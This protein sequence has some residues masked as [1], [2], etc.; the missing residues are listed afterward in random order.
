MCGEDR[1]IHQTADLKWDAFR[2]IRDKGDSL[3]ITFA[4]ADA[5]SHAILINDMGDA[6]H[7]FKGM[8]LAVLTTIFTA[9]ANE[10]IHLS[11]E[12]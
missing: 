7:H 6:I 10:L 4:D 2:F 8:E 12:T 1:V 3:V 5:A 11:D 9:C